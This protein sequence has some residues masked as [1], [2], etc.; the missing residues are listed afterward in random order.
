MRR[1]CATLTYLGGEKVLKEM[2]VA[3]V[4]VRLDGNSTCGQGEG[5]VNAAKAAGAVV[6]VAAVPPP[7]L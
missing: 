1:P 6:A 2:L 3:G 7:T 5:E 4:L